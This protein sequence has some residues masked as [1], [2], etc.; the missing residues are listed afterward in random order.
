MIERPSPFIFPKH[1]HFLLLTGGVLPIVKP[2][3]SPR[4]AL[5]FN[6]QR[7]PKPFVNDNLRRTRLYL[8]DEKIWTEGGNDL[9]SNGW[10]S[11]SD[12]NYIEDWQTRSKRETGDGY[13]LSVSDENHNNDEEPIQVSDFNDR[14]SSEIITEEEQAEAYLDNLAALVNEEVEFNFKD[15]ERAEMVREMQG[16]GFENEVIA[17]ALDISMEEIPTD[18]VEEAME[19][20][21]RESYSNDV[22]IDWTEVPS[23]LTVDLD[24][25]TGLPER[26]QNVYVDELACIGCYLCSN[27]AESTFF[28]ESEYGRARVFKQWGDDDETVKAAIESCPVDCIHYVDYDDL[29]RLEKEREGQVINFKARLVGGDVNAHRVGGA[30]RYSQQQEIAGNL[31]ACCN[32]CPS[33]GCESCP[34]YG[35]GKN[36]IFQEREAARYVREQRRKI[37]QIRERESKVAEL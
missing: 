1:F 17:S 3:V 36:P 13:W 35:V 14:G 16:W 26:S 12:K 8:D 18:S 22:D 33:R 5:S 19:T 21:E 31:G 37:K 7:R 10:R 32:N 23:H 2:L 6:K 24:E 15:A 28:M 4:L 11:S 27:V 25:D 30:V 20:W 9:D 34:M 29:V